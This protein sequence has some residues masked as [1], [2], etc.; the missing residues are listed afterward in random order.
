MDAVEESN[1]GNALPPLFD[2][3][4]DNDTAEYML[5]VFNGGQEGTATAASKPLAR[6]D[7]LRKAALRLSDPLTKDYIWQRD[8]FDF[9]VVSRKGMHLFLLGSF[10]GQLS[11]ARSSDLDR[12]TS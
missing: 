7:Q 3:A 11:S 10:P 4:L 5:F 12:Q 9:Q 1:S 8:G 2:G 6:L